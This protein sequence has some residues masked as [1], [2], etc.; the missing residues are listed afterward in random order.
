VAAGGRE[1]VARVESRLAGAA[2][3]GSKYP[4]GSRNVDGAV[5]K[6]LLRRQ[7]LTGV[8]AAVGVLRRWPRFGLRKVGLT[9]RQG[10]SPAW[11]R[12]VGVGGRAGG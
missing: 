1:D 6:S 11:K 3:G 8:V 5:R 9:R 7:L 12:G 2:W 4:H 10:S